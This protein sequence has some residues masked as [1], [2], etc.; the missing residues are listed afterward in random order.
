M[1]C[2]GCKKKATGDG[3]ETHKA[4]QRVALDDAIARL[5]PGAP[6]GPTWGQLDAEAAFGGG[7][8]P[9]EVRRLGQALSVAAR[10]PTFVRPGGDEDLCTFVYLLCVGRAPGLLD[11]RDER[12]PVDLGA[13]EERVRERWLRVALSSV[14]RM[15][16]VQEVA[17]ELDRL[18]ASTVEIRELGRPGVYDPILLKR[19]R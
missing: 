3:C 6:G 15:A 11:V 9:A 5:Y 4:P 16:T 1:S 12:V 10:A 2:A 19:M 8:R 18:D 7:I 17:F 14:A 13:G